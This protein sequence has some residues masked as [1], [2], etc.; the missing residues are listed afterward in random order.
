MTA[1]LLL[2][3]THSGPRAG[4]RYHRGDEASPMNAPDPAPTAGASP[5]LAAFLRGIGRRA[6]LFADLQ[7]GP[8]GD[9]ALA[10]ALPG[11]LAHAAHQPMSRWPERFWGQL[12]ATP[13][14]RGTCGEDRTA[15][16]LWLVAGLDEEGAAAALGVPGEDWRQAVQRAAPRDAAG[17]VDTAAWQAWAESVRDQLR[18]LRQERLDWWDGECT[19]ALHPGRPPATRAARRRVPRWLLPMLWAGV[20]LCVLGLVVSFVPR[21]LPAGDGAARGDAPMRTRRASLPAPAEPAARYD[22]DFALHHDRDLALLAGGDEALL[23]DL[24]FHAW[25]AAQIGA[26]PA[27][28]GPLV[29]P[30]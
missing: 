2:C 17:Q 1:A 18:G 24:D 15:A 25:H 30:A 16:L 20:A 3:T 21:G 7:A 28:A 6:I 22:T 29:D 23:R 26:A 13:A 4:D 5:A 9:R 10:A 14:L 27:P 19:Q 12:L 11:F 8:G